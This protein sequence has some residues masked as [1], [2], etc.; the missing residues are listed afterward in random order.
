MARDAILQSNYQTQKVKVMKGLLQ[1]QASEGDK[2]E[3]TALYQWYI[4]RQRKNKKRIS[5][6][7]V[8]NKCMIV[9]LETLGMGEVLSL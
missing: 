2:M 1:Q 5:L 9:R 7:V 6:M 3:T 8:S 4:Q